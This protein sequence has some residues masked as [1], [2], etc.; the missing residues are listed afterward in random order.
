MV[1][2]RDDL[3]VALCSRPCQG[4]ITTSQKRLLPSGDV[5]ITGT[6]P[7]P[8]CTGCPERHNPKLLRHLE[9][10]FET[11]PGGGI[12]DLVDTES[13]AVEG[14]AIIRV[15]TTILRYFLR[16]SQ[17]RSW[18]LRVVPGGSSMRPWERTRDRAATRLRPT[19]RPGDG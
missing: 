11:E 4:P 2:L 19:Q 1:A 13:A 3:I 5:E 12:G 9:V 14:A 16:G 7:P 10:Q 17:F 8:L 6:V 15:S 18:G